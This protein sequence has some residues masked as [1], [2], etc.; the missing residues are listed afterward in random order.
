MKKRISFFVGRRGLRLLSGTLVVASI[1]L[2]FI[3]G[4]LN[5]APKITQPAQPESG[6][7]GKDYAHAGVKVTKGGRGYN[8]FYVFEPTDPKPA[9][10]PVTFITHG[11]LE[12]SGYGH[13]SAFI[14][15]TV[16]KGNV[17]IYP[18]Y[19]TTPWTPCLGFLNSKGCMDSALKGFRDGLALLQ[20]DPARVQPELDK[21]SYFGFSYGGIITANLTNHW[22]ELGLP[23]PR[24]IFLDDPHDGSFFTPNEPA[25]EFSL[26]GI[27]ATTLFQCHVGQAG[28]V[29]EVQMAPLL[30]SSCN[31]VFPRISHIP[32]ENKDLVM[33]NIDRHGSPA[34]VPKHG[35]S[36]TMFGATNAYDH[37]FVWKVFDALRS[38]AFDGVDCEYALGDTPEHRSM[39]FWSDGTPIKPL[40]IQDESPILP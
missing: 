29:S 34:L 28:V 14:K 17:V 9:S 31:T 25:L 6:P 38:C 2:C 16:R 3:S 12:F 15:H 13:H 32:A 10:A 21:A 36:Q 39:G 18:R 27:P 8:A 20:A 24:V 4:N 1:G 19:Q 11:Y 5:A 40:T 23:E 33:S 35:V 37:H 30:M 22:Q 26:D 7:G